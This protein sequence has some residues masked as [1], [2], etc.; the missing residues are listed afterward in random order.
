MP[1]YHISLVGDRVE[2]HIAGGRAT[3]TPHLSDEEWEWHARDRNNE[4][5]GGKAPNLLET[6]RQSVSYVLLGSG[7]P[8]ESELP[9]LLKNEIARKR[10]L[11]FAGHDPESCE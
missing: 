6:I 4:R 9:E 11:W 10:L 7:V 2:I 8:M 5:K 1:E 3:L